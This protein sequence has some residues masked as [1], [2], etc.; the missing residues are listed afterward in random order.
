[1]HSIGMWWYIYIDGYE[2][3]TIQNPISENN[4]GA[5]LARQKLCN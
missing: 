2:H 3:E 5:P 1:M 4:I